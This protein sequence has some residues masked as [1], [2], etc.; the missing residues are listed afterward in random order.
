MA[1]NEAYRQQ[2]NLLIQTL[3]HIAEKEC[4]ALKGGTA[5][6]LFIRDLPRL[7][8][9]IDLTY[10]P[11]AGR[12]EALAE[13]ESALLRIADKLRRAM[14]GASIREI[15]APRDGAVTK[16]QVQRART[17]IKIEVT[18]V[19]RGC[20]Y[21]PEWRAVSPR[22]EDEFGFAEIQVVS[23]ADLYAGKIVAALDRQHPRDLFDVR[24]LLANEGVDDDLRQAF[25]IYLLSGSRPLAEL[26]APTRKDIAA[27]F[28]RG[29]VGM[30]N[31]PITLDDLTTAREELIK[32]MVGEMPEDHRE[33][34]LSANIS[35]GGWGSNF[36]TGFIRRPL[37][38]AW[39]WKTNAA[40]PG[41]LLL[42]TVI[43]RRH[44]KSSNRAGIRPAG[45]PIRRPGSRP[46]ARSSPWPGAMPPGR[47]SPC[48]CAARPIRFG[49]GRRC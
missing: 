48:S 38:N 13:I 49:S 34:L 21:K 2:V 24:D 29:F 12:K 28:E 37:A 9:D 8:V 1:I 19:L 27:E 42:P 4:F 20:V 43:M 16:L 11:D 22:V 47:R 7:S 15:T 18:P 45:W 39:R 25:L 32:I 23:F 26:L 31:Q 41:C 40:W 33:F 14:P 46:L 30:T 35:H 17:Q 3:P 6:N 44:W 36:A 10:L 5:I